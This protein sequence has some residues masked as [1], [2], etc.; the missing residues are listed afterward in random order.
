MEGL[1]F[2]KLER[3]NGGV[4]K[5]EEE[6]TEK[7]K[8]IIN[9]KTCMNL[10]DDH[11]DNMFS[12]IF[13]NLDSVYS[14]IEKR[15]MFISHLITD[16]IFCLLEVIKMSNSY[17]I[18]YIMSHSYIGFTHDKLIDWC[19][20]YNTFLKIENIYEASKYSILNKHEYNLLINFDESKKYFDASY[21]KRIASDTETKLKQ[22]IGADNMH[23]VSTRY[24]AELAIDHL[25]AARQVHSGGNAYKNLIENMSYLNDDFCDKQ[26]HFCAALERF[27]LINGKT[28]NKL[29][30]LFKVGDESGI[31]NI[32]NY[33]SDPLNQKY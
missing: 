14:E 5:L 31:F 4:E 26:Y 25:F 6:F 7:I 23:I 30:E 13:N 1:G 33:A 17:G 22:L 9:N 18:S 19:A 32:K 3:K 28:K 2:K 21:F 20:F 8:E 24:H 12:D 29:D 11:F 27:Y 16:S 10:L 15:L